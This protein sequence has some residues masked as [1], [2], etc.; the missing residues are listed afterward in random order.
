MRTSLNYP[1]RASGL[2]NMDLQSDRLFITHER[3]PFHVIELWKPES[4]SRFPLS[5]ARSLH[6][7]RLLIHNSGIPA[8]SLV[9]KCWNPKAQC[10][11]LYPEISPSSSSRRLLNL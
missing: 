10:N 4:N 9:V 8:D 11:V 6:S 7:V 1:G 2:N 5:R 3:D